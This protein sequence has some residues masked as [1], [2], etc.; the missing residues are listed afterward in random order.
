MGEFGETELEP[1]A[2]AAP[3]RGGGRRIWALLRVPFVLAVV[4][5]FLYAVY[6]VSYTHLTLPTIY[7]V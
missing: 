6:P 4:A 2:A 1:P 7:S 3:G 5:L